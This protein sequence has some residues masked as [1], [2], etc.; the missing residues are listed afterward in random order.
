[1]EHAWCDPLSRIGAAAPRERV[2]SG[3]IGAGEA[4]Q[5]GASVEDHEDGAEDAHQRAEN[6]EHAVFGED[7]EHLDTDNCGQ[8]ECE[9]R[10]GGLERGGVGGVG[11]AEA[12]QEEELVGEDPAQGVVVEETKR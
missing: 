12:E 9:D 3:G 2:A 5:G 4:D 6:L 10:Y 11:E 7:V 1:L 8:E